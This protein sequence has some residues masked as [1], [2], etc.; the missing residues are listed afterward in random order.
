MTFNRARFD[1]LI[2]KL[3]RSA[4]SAD[5]L[6]ELGTL[7]GQLSKLNEGR[8]AL[9]KDVQ[10]S[11]D[12]NKLTVLEVFGTARK[13]GK[14]LVEQGVKPDSVFPPKAATGATGEDGQATPATLNAVERPS[15]KNEELIKSKGHGK[16]FIYKRGRVFEDAKGEPTTDLKKVYA[17]ALSKFFTT[18]KTAAAITEA[19]TPEGKEYFKTE[20]GKK[21]LAK[22]VELAR[23]A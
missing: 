13:L 6:K 7:Q 19:A 8:E 10:K 15:N 21:E 20:E 5:E 9:I 18:H 3:Q 17:G 11:I 22:L 1:E 16:P 14:L 2:S 23:L 12:E 4:L